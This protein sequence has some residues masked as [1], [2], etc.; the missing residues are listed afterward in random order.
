M[1]RQQSSVPTGDALSTRLSC[2]SVEFLAVRPCLLVFPEDLLPSMRFPEQQQKLQSD[3]PVSIS[4]AGEQGI[5]VQFKPG[6]VSHRA[7]ES[8]GTDTHGYAFSGLLQ[9]RPEAICQ[10]ALALCAWRQRSAISGRFPGSINQIPFM[11]LQAVLFGELLS[12]FVLI[13][14]SPYLPGCWATHS[15][16]AGQELFPDSSCCARFNLRMTIAQG[17]TRERERAQ[18]LQF[19]ISLPQNNFLCKTSIWL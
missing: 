5:A 16:S 2:F 17:L 8:E 13:I 3:F 10:P 12:S 15:L 14:L 1:G 11:G 18:L 4:N 19:C 6:T 9:A 7:C